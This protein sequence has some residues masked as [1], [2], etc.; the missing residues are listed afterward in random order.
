MAIFGRE[1][2]QNFP[3]SPLPPPPAKQAQCHPLVRVA[4]S[5]GSGY[6]PSIATVGVRRPGGMGAAVSVFGSARCGLP[7]GEGCTLSEIQLGA[8][9]QVAELF[10]VHNLLF[11]HGIRALLIC[12]TG[13]SQGHG[14]VDLRMA[15]L[16]EG[17]S[18]VRTNGQERLGRGPIYMTDNFYSFYVKSFFTVGIFHHAGWH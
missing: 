18:E 16:A 4:Q 2:G 9:G 1:L 15:R 8:R 6:H 17:E 7:L 10:G 12:V 14:I 13:V 5:I 11:R 3:E